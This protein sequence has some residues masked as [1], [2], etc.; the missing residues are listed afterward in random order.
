MSLFDV[1]ENTCYSAMIL[2]VVFV[3]AICLTRI[4]A[5]I[6]LNLLLTE[7]FGFANMQNVLKIRMS[8]VMTA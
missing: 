2:L 8:A 4:E 3:V 1:I 6:W 7:K 5:K